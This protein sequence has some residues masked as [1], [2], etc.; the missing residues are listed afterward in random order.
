MSESV[1]PSSCT[2]GEQDESSSSLT[3]TV[4]SAA[5]SRT[6]QSTPPSVSRAQFDGPPSR[7]ALFSGRVSAIIHASRH[8][9]SP[10]PSSPRPTLLKKLTYGLMQASA[11]THEPGLTTL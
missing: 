1:Q 10:L 7:L 5:P 4:Y 2:V 6:K 11:V 8:F 3:T 9:S